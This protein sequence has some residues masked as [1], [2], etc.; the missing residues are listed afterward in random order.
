MKGQ[1][2]QYKEDVCC[3]G[4]TPDS[5][6]HSRCIPICGSN[7]VKH[8]T[9][10]AP[11]VCKCNKGYMMKN[12]KCS[13]I[14]E[15]KCINGFCSA[16]GI[17]SCANGFKRDKANAA[18]CNPIC[19]PDCSE[20]SICVKSMPPN[21]NRC[22]CLSGY[23]LDPNDKKCKPFCKSTCTNG[24]C[25]APD[26]CDCFIGFEL[27]KNNKTNCLPKCEPMCQPFS[28]CVK[29]NECECIEGY[30]FNSVE[31]KCEPICTDQIKYSRCIAPP[32]T[33]ECIDNYQYDSRIG[34]CVLDSCSC[35]SGGYCLDHKDV[36]ECYKG[37]TKNEKTGQ[38]ESECK[39][40]CE[41]SICVEN[42][43][44]QCLN[45]YHQTPVDHICEKNDLCN[46]KPCHN[47][48]CLITGECQCKT[49]FI[50]SLSYFGQ[51][52]CDKIE[53]F[54]GKVMTTILG[55]PLLLALFILII[56]YVMAK[57]RTYR[58]EEQ[59]KVLLL[60]HIYNYID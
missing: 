53:T 27:D 40:E 48:E 25:S 46:G 10:I 31:K 51:S 47:G 21:S 50:K 56:V 42:N 15:N 44:C 16:P 11:N 5:T 49:G 14:C 22:E 13:P 1:T 34:K 45:G 30:K 26:N 41:N 23:V 6:N 54:I 52:Q 57:K 7:C 9:C 24:F 43:V 18:L 17:C 3:E 20:F 2:Y 32:N 29:P 35:N 12:N 38:C 19:K 55:I 58:V 37:Y 59:G 36:C 28:K 60:F 33:W 4:Y 8:G 39:P